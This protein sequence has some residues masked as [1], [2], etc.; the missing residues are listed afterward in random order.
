MCSMIFFVFLFY[1]FLGRDVLFLFVFP[2]KIKTVESGV[3]GK[4][5][6]AINVGYWEVGKS[7]YAASQNDSLLWTQTPKKQNF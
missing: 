6:E 2:D 4:R 3:Y 5:N 1:N 7:S